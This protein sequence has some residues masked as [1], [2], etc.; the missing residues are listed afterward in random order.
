MLTAAAAALGSAAIGG[1]ASAFGA[2]SANKANWKIAK[3]QM[4]FQERM[5]NTSV[6]R[7]VEDLKAAGINPILAGNISASS[8]G[9]ASAVMQ[10]VGSAAV[11]GA[12][13]A[14]AI[15][16]QIK[17]VGAQVNHTNQQARK[18]AANARIAEQT[19][20]FIEKYPSVVG[21][22][23]G[24]P[25]AVASAFDAGKGLGTDVYENNPIDLGDAVDAILKRGT[26][27][28]DY[29]PATTYPA[30]PQPKVKT[31]TFLQRRA[32]QARENQMKYAKKR[33]PGKYD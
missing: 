1:L 6:Q 12:Q 18:E 8:P 11:S 23:Y 25:G 22:L 31:E 9:G 16:N 28:R 21:G 20:A 4:E 2:S 3:K 5:S 29:K 27:A 26:S 14:A 24:T 30:K 32:R 13:Q 10:N 15:R 19:A 33:W 7:R 17:Q